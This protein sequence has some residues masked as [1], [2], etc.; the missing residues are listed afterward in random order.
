MRVAD[1]ANDVALKIVKTAD[2]VENFFALRIQQQ[3]VDGEVTALH[4]KPGFSRELD[5]IGMAAI[6]IS[7]VTAVRGH[8]DGVVV[9]GPVWTVLAN[10]HQHHAELGAHGVGKREEPHYVLRSSRSG[11]V[12]IGRLAAKYKIPHA[13]AHKVSR[14][15]VPAQIVYDARS[16]LSSGRREIHLFFGCAMA[17][18][19]SSSNNIDVCRKPAF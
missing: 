9:A 3:T 4:I 17:R 19:F 7:T 8:L 2:I 14:V 13:A 11:N 10:R 1:G 5:L 15:P 6:R 12:I 16:F 18:G